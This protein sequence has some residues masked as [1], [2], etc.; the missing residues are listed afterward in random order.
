MK[1]VENLYYIRVKNITG[2]TA[3]GRTEKHTYYN[4]DIMVETDSYAAAKLMTTNGKKTLNA[5]NDAIAHYSGEDLSTPDGVEKLK[6]RITGNL[7]EAY[8]TNKISNIYMEKYLFQ[9][10]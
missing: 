5:I 8:R 6:Y 3:V 2:T 10:K 7:A 9:N 1:Q 4:M